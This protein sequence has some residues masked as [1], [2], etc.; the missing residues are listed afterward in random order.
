MGA[1]GNPEDFFYDSVVA[2]EYS[3][4]SSAGAAA[5]RQQVGRDVINS[6]R[7]PA[8]SKV[9]LLSCQ[10]V[11]AA[12]D[13][14]TH[15]RHVTIIALHCHTVYSYAV[16]ICKYFVYKSL[17]LTFLAC[18]DFSLLSSFIVILLSFGCCGFSVCRTNKG[19][20]ICT[21]IIQ[22]PNK[23][24]EEAKGNNLTFSGLHESTI[25]N[26]EW[27]GRLHAHCSVSPVRK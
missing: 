20:L 13:G 4:E 3:M 21:L 16:Y 17:F 22:N 24:P 6:S 27:I 14:V 11:I 19:I 26:P 1:G 15:P 25:S 10:A 12:G 18:F 8:P 5:S 23:T 9:V 2:S 7:R